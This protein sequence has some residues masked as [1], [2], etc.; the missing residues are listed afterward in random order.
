MKSIVYIASSNRSGS[1]LLETLLGKHDCVTSLGELRHLNEYVRDDRLCTCGNPISVC[2]F[3]QRVET[4]MRRDG[5]SLSTMPTKIAGSRSGG[6]SGL[7]MIEVLLY[8]LS[9]GLFKIVRKIPFGLRK[10]IQVA[11]NCLRVAVT[12]SKVTGCPIIA[13]SSKK[14][15][16]LRLLYLLEPRKLKV[17]FL[18]R[19][20][21]GVTYSA[22]RRKIISVR[23]AS[24][25]W[26]LDNL[27]IFLSIQ[28]IPSR[29]R[30]VVKYE[31][32]C[33]D[34]SLEMERICTFLE[35]PYVPKTTALSKDH[36]HSI[37]GSPHRFN[38]A[39]VQIVLDE[40]WK[41]ELSAEQLMKF[42]YFPR[43]LNR[44]IGYK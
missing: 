31:N 32:F 40:R 19:D 34:P 42:G 37:G 22:M 27:R 29:Q 6:G 24:Y 23:E 25:L 30:I 13:D 9:S 14:P 2:P 36:S 7:I 15:I 20:V 16:M 12:V 3:W 39:E 17:V 4:E 21:R 11:E 44:L 41:K 43:L 28:T 35:I 33:K 26:L 10:Y 38:K 8:L 5:W 1:T 18:I